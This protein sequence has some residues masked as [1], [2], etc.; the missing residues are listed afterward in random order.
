MSISVIITTPMIVIIIWI[1]VF[2]LRIVTKV[3]FELPPLFIFAVSSS[4]ALAI[5]LLPVSG[6]KKIC[7]DRMTAPVNR[8]G[9]SWAPVLAAL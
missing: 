6:V 2:M 7:P 9:I 5:A 1:S 3:Y 8:S 4:A